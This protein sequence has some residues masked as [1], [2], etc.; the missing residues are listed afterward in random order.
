MTS[1]DASAQRLPYLL[2]GAFKL[3]ITGIKFKPARTGKQLYFIE[4]E[5]LESNNAQRPVGMRVS[6]CIDLSNVDM[7][8]PNMSQFIAAVHG[9]DPSQ[10]QRDSTVAPWADP[11]TRQPMPWGHYGKESLHESN[12]WAGREVGVYVETIA[13]QSDGK[14]F[15]RHTW[16]PAARMSVPAAPQMPAPPQGGQPG[17]PPPQGGQ[18]GFQPP[19]GG[20]QWSPPP[21]QGGWGGQRGPGG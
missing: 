21:G 12:P 14:P 16:V 13:K 20:Q 8:G 5:I 4:T 18:Q 2:D 11:Q 10:L 9:F 3:R 7:R 1:G 19:Q 15:A 6:S 17:F